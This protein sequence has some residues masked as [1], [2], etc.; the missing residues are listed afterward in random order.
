MCLAVLDPGCLWQI[1]QTPF[2]PLLGQL[3]SIWH[4]SGE[5]SQSPSLDQFRTWKPV[6]TSHTFEIRCYQ[7]KLSSELRLDHLAHKQE[8][9]AASS[10]FEVFLNYNSMS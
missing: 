4:P 9:P 5:W 3:F 7:S 2:S 8:N 6:A 10:A 1:F